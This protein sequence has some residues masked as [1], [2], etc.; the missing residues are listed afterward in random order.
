MEVILNQPGKYLYIRRVGER[1]I[2][3][4]DRELCRSFAISRERVIEDWIVQ[5]SDDL[6][7]EHLLPLLEL[8]PEVVLIGSGRK[9]QFPSP[10]SMAFLLSRGIGCEV[11][12]NAAVAR[13]FNVLANEDRAVV[14]A[15]ILPN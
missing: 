11:M 1:G 6:R 3:V 5:S 13:T 8:Q 4:V 7:P 15:F 10:E 9:L 2:V 12:D 14:A